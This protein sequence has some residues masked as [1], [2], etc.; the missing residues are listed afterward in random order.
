MGNLTGI[1]CI[2]PVFDASG[3][4]EWCRNYILCL[5]KEGIPVTIG[6]DPVRKT[7]R[8]ITIEGVHPDLG[9]KGAIL[10]E[11]VGKDIDYN[12]VISWLT[13]PLAVEQMARESHAKRIVMTLWETDRIH[14]SWSKYCNFLDEVW[15][16]GS[17]NKEVF[18]SSFKEQLELHPEY[19]NLS[20]IPIRTVT[21]PIAFEDYETSF[22]AK[23]KHPV[24]GEILDDDYYLFY[25]ISQWTERKNFA[26]L[27]IA[28]WSEFSADDKVVLFLKTYRANY[29]QQEHDLIQNSISNLAKGCNKENLPPVAVIR[30][31][32]SKQQI[33]AL[34]KACSCY[35]SPA[36][37]EGLGLGMLEAALFENPVITNL[38][39][40]QSSYINEN[41][42]FIYNYTL[43]PVTGTGIRSLYTM[44][45]N[46][47]SPD[48][49]DLANKMRFVFENRNEATKKGRALKSYL[50]NT[51]TSEKVAH[52]IKEH[53]EASLGTVPVKG[54]KAN[55]G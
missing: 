53:L 42:G 18:T 51:C 43:R 4:A 6:V 20:S 50:L 27:L 31:L 5:I 16:P 24:T 47:A 22:K 23:L 26:D 25:S 54:Y 55:A 49:K 39:G 40:E 13:P 3:Y 7:G 14:P 36:R 2:G 48:V 28:Y 1:K 34:H 52:E 15:L 32:L 33:L 12:V 17:F 45:Q 19:S 11:H 8:P 44:E 38:F 29:S 10:E 46:W 21:Y 35:V 37:G 30:Q 9:E 41:R